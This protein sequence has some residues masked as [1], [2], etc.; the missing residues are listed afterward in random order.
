MGNA[1]ALATLDSRL[2]GKDYLWERMRVANYAN[3]HKSSGLIYVH[4]RCW[5]EN[6]FVTMRLSRLNIF[7]EEQ[8]REE[9]KGE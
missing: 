9:A 8:S 2:R 6:Y 3:A 4:F 5:N 7:D 1:T